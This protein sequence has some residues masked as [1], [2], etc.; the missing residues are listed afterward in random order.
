[1]GW[2]TAAL[3]GE[4]HYFLSQRHCCHFPSGPA[5]WLPRD[6]PLQGCEADCSHLPRWA[7]HR[8]RDAEQTP[9]CSCPSRECLLCPRGHRGHTDS[10]TTLKQQRNGSQGRFRTGAGL[11][12]VELVS[13]CLS[14]TSTS[15]ILLPTSF[16]S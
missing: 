4:L 15:R 1:M 7:V 16:D 5:A 8:G 11:A 6:L 14:L 9:R 3:P 2:K 10:D 12:L 13:F